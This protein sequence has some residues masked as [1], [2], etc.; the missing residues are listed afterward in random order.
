MIQPIVPELCVLTNGLLCFVE[1]PYEVGVSEEKSEDGLHV[2]VVDIVDD[3]AAN[4]LGA[5]AGNFPCKNTRK[6]RRRKW[7]SSGTRE[8]TR[9]REK[10][11]LVIQMMLL[12]RRSGSAAI[13]FEV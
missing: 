6:V 7:R 4:V 13:S 11:D 1:V 3:G 9:E 12:H 10:N 5:I 8:D 2:R